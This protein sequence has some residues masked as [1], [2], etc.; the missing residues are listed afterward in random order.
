[1]TRRAKL[2]LLAFC[3]PHVPA[4]RA[5]HRLADS[6][7]AIHANLGIPEGLASGSHRLSRP[8]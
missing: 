6:K 3:Y 7:L 8:R 2:L 5:L 4:K 1:M